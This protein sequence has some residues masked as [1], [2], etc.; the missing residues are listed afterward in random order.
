MGWHYKPTKIVYPDGS[1]TWEIR[2]FYESD[3][4]DG[5]TADA[6][7]PF[8]ESL[9]ELRRTLQMM[10]ADVDRREPLMLYGYTCEKCG[11]LRT[12]RV[13]PQKVCDDCR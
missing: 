4:G 10:L 1:E 9:E 12:Q 7:S 13:R 8:G 11:K 5:W 6:V 2:E 3:G